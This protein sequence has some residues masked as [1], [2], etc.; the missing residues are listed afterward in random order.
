MAKQKSEAKSSVKT[1]QQGIDTEKKKMKR[2]VKIYQEGIAT[3]KQ[4]IGAY[5]KKMGG[6][7]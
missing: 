1:Y 5:T 6:S 7:A 4:K 3:E 2:S